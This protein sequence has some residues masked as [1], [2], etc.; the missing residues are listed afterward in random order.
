MKIAGIIC[1]ILIY[2][3]GCSQK[4]DSESASAD[5]LSSYSLEN[6]VYVR[7]TIG[8][9]VSWK[10]MVPVRFYFSKQ[11]PGVW[12]ELIQEAAQS[13]K[14]L[15]GRHLIEID[16]NLSDSAA[17]TN[18]RKNI[19]YWIDS[20]MLFNYQQATT[21]TRWLKNQIIDSDILINSKDFVFYAD[22]PETNYMIHFKS[23][24]IHEFGHALGLK[25]TPKTV[26]VMYPELG[27]LEVRNSLSDSDITS[28]KCE[29]P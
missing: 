26:S 2:T 27:F 3:I 4:A 16:Y 9:I 1:L 7:N 10:S 24:L 15:S 23:L 19:I 22:N 18:D 21:M 25:H 12:R 20:G 29:Y 6:C 13:W 11:V 28:V 17:P 5:E 14:T 8:Q